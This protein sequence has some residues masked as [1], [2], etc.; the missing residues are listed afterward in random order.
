M[1]VQDDV[2]LETCERAALEM[3]IDCLRMGSVTG[4][5]GAHFGGGLS[6]VEIMASLYLGVMHVDATRPGW[7]ERDRF[8]LS[9]GHGAMAYYAALKQ[10]GFITDDEMMRSRATTRSCTATP[11]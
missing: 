1:R 5:G 6:M 10:T 3:R 9:K 11:R 7:D 4:L 8:I 2:A